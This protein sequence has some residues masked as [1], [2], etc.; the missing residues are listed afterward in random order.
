[1]LNVL[2]KILRIV[3]TLTIWSL[4]GRYRTLTDVTRHYQTLPDPEAPNR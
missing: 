2:I 3:N 4:W 1:M